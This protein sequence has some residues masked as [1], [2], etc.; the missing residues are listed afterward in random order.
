MLFRSDLATLVNEVVTVARNTATDCLLVF[1]PGGIT[2]HPDHQRATEAALVA[3]G[4]LGIPVLAWALAPEVATPL[5]TEFGV[6]FV[7][8][9]H[10]QIHLRL[11]VDRTAQLAAIACHASQSPNNPVLRRRLEL[12]GDIESLRWLA[13]PADVGA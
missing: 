6:Q 11:R 7:A 4:Q 3:A 13:P 12:Q 5:H 1:D 9:E 2:G 10:D 8:T